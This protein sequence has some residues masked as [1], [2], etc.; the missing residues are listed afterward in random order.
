MQKRSENAQDT[1]RQ[2][3]LGLPDYKIL[4]R[5]A[6]IA[7]PPPPFPEPKVEAQ[8]L[9]QHAERTAPARQLGVI[10]AL[11]TWIAYAGWDLFNER[12]GP[13]PEVILSTVFPLRAAGALILFIGYIKSRSPD[14]TIPLYAERVISLSIITCYAIL[15]AMIF[16][17]P[18]PTSYLFY[19]VG[20]FLVMLFTFGLFSLPA[21]VSI[22][23]LII[24]FMM[25]FVSLPL[26][27]ISPNSN[28]AIVMTDPHA[29]LKPLSDYYFL[30]A[31]TYLASFVMA[32][33]LIASQFERE[34]R[35]AFVRERDLKLLYLDVQGKT[36]ALIAAKDAIREYAI[37]DMRNKSV[38]LANLT[39][40]LAQPL[41]G[42][43]L[44]VSNLNIAIKND[45]RTVMND[46]IL[47]IKQLLQSTRAS[48]KSALDHEQ[49]ESGLQTPRYSDFSIS[50]VID[51]VI[52]TH[53]SS[54]SEKGVTLRLR[55]SHK[56]YPYVR[57][58]RSM[59]SRAISN[60]VSNSIKYSDMSK[61]D[62][63]GVLINVVAFPS[64]V[65]IDVVDNGI[66]I[67]QSKWTEV[68]KPLAQLNN[69]ERNRDK[70]LGLGLAIVKESIEILERHRIDMRSVES[71]WTRFSIEIP[72]S[73]KKISPQSQIS[74]SS[75]LDDVAENLGDLFILYI[76]DDI[77]VR[78][79]TVG[80]LETLGM[81]VEH[82]DSVADLE[83]NIIHIERRPDVVISDHRLPDG[84]TSVDV[85]NICKLRWGNDI[86]FLVVTGN[87][88]N[89]DS[90]SDQFPGASNVMVRI[91]PISGDELV[92]AFTKMLKTL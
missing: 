66:G 59:I 9:N 20:L 61:G 78:Q 72:I 51:D 75:M 33:S 91:K 47:S 76:E 41:Y 74:A 6:A 12:T 27:Q 53:S 42:I 69:P 52:T 11:A 82:A 43:S 70:G 35:A 84:K 16:V 36:D 85:F 2:L 39:H 83:S 64:R 19:Y 88:M 18:F 65:R 45:D 1:P 24:C 71:K 38:Y 58:D 49:L 40:D 25:S 73:D 60:I 44:L 68:F 90:F 62:R 86:N 55:A 79:A 17:V 13:N 21:K 3:K 31:V 77:V 28:S 14:F 5:I 46:N 15:S 48:F 89:V 50:D 57:S 10:I 67:P 81:L 22:K 4:K 37:D 80:F 23:I 87:S 7:L 26:S 29:F 8:F 34:A 56:P 32:G 54:A 92:D 63:Q 30:A